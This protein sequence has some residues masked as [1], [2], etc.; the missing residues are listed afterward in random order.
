MKSYSIAAIA[1]L[2]AM[3]AG[4]CPSD[5]QTPPG[6]PFAPAEDST[7][8]DP[9]NPTKVFRMDFAR[10]ERQ[11][12]LSRA[13]LMTLTPENLAALPQEQ[14]DQIYGRIAAGPIPDGKYMGNL[15]FARGDTMRARLEEIVGGLPGRLA[16]ANI[17]ILENVGRALWKGKEI[18]RDQ[19]IL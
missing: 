13:D 6:I 4:V 9:D 1:A 12:P 15:F 10:V 7:L 19:R 11:Y 5:A 8:A 2:M 3:G 14:V 17:E 16:G 18:K